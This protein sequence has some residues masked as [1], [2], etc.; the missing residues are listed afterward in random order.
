MNK[1]LH[2]V[3]LLMAAGLFT[4]V[5]VQSS[6]GALADTQT[7]TLAQTTETTVQQI[8]S[9][10]SQGTLKVRRPDFTEVLGDR[11][12]FLPEFSAVDENGADIS[13]NVDITSN[14]SVDIDK[15]RGTIKLLEDGEHTITYSV[16]STNLSR[17]FKVTRRR[18][19]F[20]YFNLSGTINEYAD[21]NAQSCI[22]LNSGQG[23]ARFNVQECYEY[24]AEVKFNKYGVRVLTTDGKVAFA[25]NYKVGLAHIQDVSVDKGIN[26][27][28]WL[29]MQVDLMDGMKLKSE[30]IKD[31]KIME[32][33]RET[34]PTNL[35][36]DDN[37][38]GFTMAVG[39]VGTT[40]YTFING[41]LVDS[42]ERPLLEGVA[43]APGILT[44]A[45]KGEKADFVA[46]GGISI[47]NMSFIS[48]SAASAKIQSL[49]A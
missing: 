39:R 41:K 44:S 21:D 38:Q 48:G 18:V 46:S 5:S 45:E 15:E 1:K 27:N 13:A 49:L 6:N 17:S 40:L 26:T 35:V 23:V 47:T 2:I 43:T 37:Y 16:P 12:F 24:Y 29:G 33:I 25:K 11:E 4:A 32:V 36:F 31:Y 19:L 28:L 9:Q 30:K 42:F 3:S 14:K 20:D 7:A 22:S 8:V 10:T 34:K